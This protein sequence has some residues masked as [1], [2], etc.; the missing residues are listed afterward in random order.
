MSE[1]PDAR[2]DA[3]WKYRASGLAPA[4][5]QVWLQQ[6]A[7][8]AEAIEVIRALGD[9]KGNQLAVVAGGRFQN[10]F[11]GG[12][13]LRPP[14]A[15][16]QLLRARELALESVRRNQRRRFDAGDAV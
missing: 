11:E 1:S 14:P 13:R 6:F 15:V 8:F 4:V 12:T 10:G 16:E 9:A 5:V 3:R 2:T 7:R